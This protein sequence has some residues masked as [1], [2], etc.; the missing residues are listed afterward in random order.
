M[1][2][3]A[4]AWGRFSNY[5]L[6]NFTQETISLFTPLY[7]LN[8]HEGWYLSSNPP[9][10]SQSNLQIYFVN[11]PFCVNAK[12]FFVYGWGWARTTIT[13]NWVVYIL[14]NVIICNFDW[15]IILQ[16]PWIICQHLTGYSCTNK[17]NDKFWVKI[18][19]ST[20]IPPHMAK[21]Q[22]LGLWLQVDS[23]HNRLSEVL[24][25]VETI[26]MLIIKQGIREYKLWLSIN[27]TS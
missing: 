17:R 16:N 23:N 5:S 12:W 11:W 24:S 14:V 25:C 10:N 6:T 9:Y 20:T 1:S 27:I 26:V 13:T 2:S 18:Q 22:D 15:H 19:S 8:E 4:W 21:Q 3:V 7:I